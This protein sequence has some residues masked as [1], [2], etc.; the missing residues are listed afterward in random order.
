[1]PKTLGFSFKF[2]HGLCRVRTSLWPWRLN[3]IKVNI[4]DP[5][6]VKKQEISKKQAENKQ[7]SA[8][9]GI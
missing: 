4:P 8:G 3:P 6:F 1:V 9:G 7:K 5:F 2:L